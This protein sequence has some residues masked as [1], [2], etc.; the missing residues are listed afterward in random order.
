MG[1]IDGPAGELH[2]RLLDREPR[3]RQRDHLLDEI[4]AGDELG[5]GMP[6][7]VHFAIH[8]FCSSAD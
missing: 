4:D 2:V 7:R 5:H 6:T 8:T 1:G 3:R